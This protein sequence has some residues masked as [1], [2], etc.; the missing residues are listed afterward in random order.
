MKT[1][2]GYHSDALTLS[3]F[4]TA[5]APKKWPA[6]VGCQMEKDR[7]FGND[8]NS[9]TPRNLFPSFPLTGSGAALKTR[10][11]GL[12]NITHHISQADRGNDDCKYG[13]DNSARHVLL[14]RSA[15]VHSD[16]STDAEDGAEQPVRRNHLNWRSRIRPN[17]GIKKNPAYRSYTRP[18]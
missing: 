10:A 14:N 6:S 16:E 17:K 18:H 2:V 5:V 1:P 11:L 15:Q 8:Y 9:L 13:T 3:N 12:K 4:P 7:T